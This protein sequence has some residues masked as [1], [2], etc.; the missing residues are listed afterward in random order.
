MLTCE[1]SNG[2]PTMTHCRETLLLRMLSFLAI[3]G[4]LLLY[5]EMD[6]PLKS[7]P[8]SKPKEKSESSKV[9][10]SNTISLQSWTRALLGNAV[11]PICVE[12]ASPRSIHLHVRFPRLS[13]ATQKHPGDQ[14]SFPTESLT[15]R[16]S[17]LK[18]DFCFCLTKTILCF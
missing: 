17:R 15:S 18:Q 8:T 3:I 12:I 2:V 10:A 4:P 5:Q 7:I 11:K 9:S 1:V 14:S 13:L 6:V 16:Q